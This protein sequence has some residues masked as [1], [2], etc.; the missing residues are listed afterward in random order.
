MGRGLLLGAT[1]AHHR[2]IMQT[3]KTSGRLATPLMMLQDRT[4][5]RIVI[6]HCFGPGV[7]A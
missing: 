7:G 1:G 3:R 5:T 6:W 4:L 2:D